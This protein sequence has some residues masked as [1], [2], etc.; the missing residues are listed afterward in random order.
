MKRR[1]E[2]EEEKGGKGRE[3]EEGICIPCAIEKGEERREENEEG[4]G[5]DVLCHF[6]SRSSCALRRPSASSPTP[7]EERGRE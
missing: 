2:K 3:E 1:K 5:Q 7:K 6:V 4:E